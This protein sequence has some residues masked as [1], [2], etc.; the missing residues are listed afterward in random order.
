MSR[1]RRRD[2]TER[3]AAHVHVG[4]RLCDLRHVAGDA[5]AARAAGLVMRVLL[6][7]R[8]REGRS[9]SSGRDSRGTERS[10]ASAA[11]ASLS[12][13]CA[14]WQLKQ[15]T[16]CAYMRLDTKSLPCMRFLWAVP[17]AKCVKV[18]SPSLCSSSFQKSP[19]SSRHESR[20]ASRSISRRWDWSGAGPANGIECRCR[21]RA[22]SRGAP[23]S[24]WFAAKAA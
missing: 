22:R 16:P 5:L 18:V 13:P 24:R 14:S 11:C 10:P 20:R 12:V 4:D 8:R 21:S 19:S 2:E 17:S 6:D 3:V 1:S 7:R 15:V 9:A 23:D